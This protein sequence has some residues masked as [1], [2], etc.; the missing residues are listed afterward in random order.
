[1]SNFAKLSPELKDMIS[2]I[3]EQGASK[4]EAVALIFLSEIAA[5]EGVPL[6]TESFANWCIECGYVRMEGEIF[7]ITG[8]GVAVVVEWARGRMRKAGL[9]P[10]E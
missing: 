10:D 3:T 8:E 1:M 9:D 2:S 7:R 4:S 5:N 6:E